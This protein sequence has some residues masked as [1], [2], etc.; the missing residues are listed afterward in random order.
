MLDRILATFGKN[1][2]QELEDFEALWRLPEADLA[3]MEDPAAAGR[4]WQ[5]GEV[6]AGTYQVLERYRDRIGPSYRLRHLGWGT[7][8]RARSPLLAYASEGHTK[9]SLIERGLQMAMAGLHPNVVATLGIWTWEDL[10]RILS[11]VSRGEPLR[12]L[13][14]PGGLPDLGRM[15]DLGI[16]L[17]RG[18]DF[19]H[20]NN[21]AHQDLCAEV[22]LVDPQGIL[23][24]DHAFPGRPWGDLRGI[25]PRLRKDRTFPEFVRSGLRGPVPGSPLGLAPESWSYKGLVQ[26]QANLWS[27][28]ALLFQMVS[29]RPPF[30][31]F[32]RHLRSPLAALKARVLSED[33]PDVRQFRADCP[34]GLAAVISLCLQRDPARRP[35][36]AAAVAEVLEGLFRDRTGRASP[37]PCFSFTHFA[38][39]NR[40]NA[41]LVAL[42]RGRDD[43]ARAR[44]D[45]ALRTDPNLPEAR[46]NRAILGWLWG[47]I[48]T[49]EAV[50]S[51]RA[52]AANLPTARRA[53]LWLLMQAGEEGEAARLLDRVE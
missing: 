9:A 19:L 21:Q 38:A 39:Q 12:Q 43:E 44:L 4:L 20:Q 36:S 6:L 35:E 33:A 16:Q 40:N 30:L 2:T 23:R 26:R 24:L 28:G 1:N 3:C 14:Q 31:P 7:E 52:A 48:G 27:L 46:V 17:C 49:S 8:I 37:Q 10:P 45:D 22:C 18:L 29:G 42:D 41:A 51:V 25:D 11:E 32:T 34:E 13:L 53:E 50:A 5:V 47:E 15:L